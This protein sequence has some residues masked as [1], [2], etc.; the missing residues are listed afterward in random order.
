[1]DDKAIAE[2]LN[3]IVK[4]PLTN[5]NLDQPLSKEFISFLQQNE[6]QFNSFKI[7]SDEIKKKI[8]IT[9]SDFLQ[10]LAQSKIPYGIISSLLNFYLYPNERTFNHL[11][12]MIKEIDTFRTMR[13]IE[14]FWKVPYYKKFIQEPF[15]CSCLLDIA[16]HYLKQSDMDVKK[17]G[18]FI[19][20]SEERIDALLTF[21]KQHCSEKDFPL[22]SPTLSEEDIS[23]AGAHNCIKP[24]YIYYGRAQY[25]DEE[26]SKQ[27]DK[28]V[29][30]EKLKLSISNYISALTYSV[31][32]RLLENKIIPQLQ[33]W[34]KLMI[35]TCS[36]F[37]ELKMWTDKL[38]SND[39]FIIT[40]QCLA[41]SLDYQN[42][43][44]R[45][46]PN[47]P[48]VIQ[49]LKE[50]DEEHY[51]YYV[52]RFIL[53]YLLKGEINPKYLDGF[54]QSIIPQAYYRDAQWKWSHFE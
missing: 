26:Y 35:Q 41:D 21:V 47:V 40:L 22:S 8:N 16:D 34:I 14:E 44:L 37:A 45:K 6:N 7:L 28:K 53:T 5:G 11:F 32:N 17:Y 15:I 30:F 20:Q 43:P 36:D 9:K 51:P 4:F 18:I 2:T 13:F 29:K 1:M 12:K 46:D 3:F 39:P 52:K 31:D 23:I 49:F 48:K 10:I 25:Y 27:T 42:K 54:D 19:L 24:Y 33:E 50:S 38:K